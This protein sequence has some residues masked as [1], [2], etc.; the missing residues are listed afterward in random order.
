MKLLVISDLHIG[1]NRDEDNFKWPT[2]EFI[3]AIE[4]IRISSGIDKIILNGDILELY[5]YSYDEIVSSPH[6]KKLFE[7][8]F[9]DLFVFIKGNHDFVSPEGV[10]RLIIK[11]K[12]NQHICIEHGHN[13]DW[14]NGTKAGRFI[15]RYFFKVVKILIKLSLIKKLYYSIVK[16]DDQIDRIPRK[17]HSIKYLNYGLKLLREFDMVIL[18]HTHKI[19]TVKTYYN[20]SKKRYLNCGTCS[21]KMLQ[22]LVIDTEDLQYDTI[23]IKDND[24]SIPADAA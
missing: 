23:K 7:Y 11:N 18:G 14:M 21:Q 4:Q 12:K 5:K 24:I 19:T 10:E 3:F 17:Y 6:N 1:I 9:R 13:A 2:D 15:G 16:W 20:L 8:L 22:G